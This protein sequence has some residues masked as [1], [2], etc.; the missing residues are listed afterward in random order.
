MLPE[1]RRPLP[2]RTG[3]T[4]MNWTCRICEQGAHKK[5]IKILSFA[6]PAAIIVRE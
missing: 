5:I 1:R 2:R 6:D 4:L 3:R